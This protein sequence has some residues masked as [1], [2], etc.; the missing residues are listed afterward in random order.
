MSPYKQPSINTVFFKAIRALVKQA[1][2]YCV[3]RLLTGMEASY[4]IMVTFD[5]IDLQYPEGDTEEEKIRHFNHFVALLLDDSVDKLQ[6]RNEL[7]AAFQIFAQILFALRDKSVLEEFNAQNN[8]PSLDMLFIQAFLIADRY[9]PLNNDIPFN[10]KS[11]RSISN[12]TG[13]WESS[14]ETWF[15]L[16]LNLLGLLNYLKAPEFTLPNQLSQE[17]VTRTFED[18]QTP[19]HYAV[20]N[21]QPKA[22][23]NLLLCGAYPNI[24]N[25]KK[26]A[27]LDLSAE[28]LQ[29]ETTKILIQY[30][31]RYSN[32]YW[33]NTS[34]DRAGNTVLHRLA[35]YGKETYPDFPISR[36][37]DQEKFL[38]HKNREGKTAL[39][40]AVESGNF[41]L[42]K[43]LCSHPYLN[44]SINDNQRRT[45]LD[46]ADINGSKEIAEFLI[47]EGAIRHQ[48]QTK[49]IKLI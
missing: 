40:L 44:I 19:L 5:M 7:E 34:A 33:S 49:Q 9:G 47:G 23:E 27:P 38:N 2:Y 10:I 30:G 3:D 36:F 11:Y 48:A 46:Y 32:N 29:V 35:I 18:G 41:D 26:Q 15:K 25:K 37:S 24:L 12:R 16:H 14:Q 4:Q 21:H 42:V 13:T 17:E 22:V 45:P 8:Q 43:Y 20:L 6:P 31:A 1:P 39:H 28:T